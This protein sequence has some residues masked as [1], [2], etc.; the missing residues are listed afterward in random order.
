[1]TSKLQNRIPVGLAA[2]AAAV[3]VAGCGS[4]GSSTITLGNESDV[5]AVPHVA[6]EKTPTTT[7]P[8]STTAKTPTSRPLSKQPKD[9][10]PS[11]AAPS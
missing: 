7:T 10:P 8:T 1:M 9:T 4:G 6:G 2:I 5:K 3:L 11:G